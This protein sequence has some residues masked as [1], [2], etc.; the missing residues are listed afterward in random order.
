MAA[1]PDPPPARGEA[2][3][4]PSPFAGPGV[5]AG[6][7]GSFYRLR[8]MPRSGGPRDWPALYTS[9][10]A[11]LEVADRVLAALVGKPWRRPRELIVFDVWTGEIVGR[12]RPDQDR[13]PDVCPTCGQNRDPFAGPVDPAPVTPIPPDTG[14]ATP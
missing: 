3:P 6:G 5:A 9:T 10:D 7:P 14:P 8:E 11:A 4:G 1:P 2:I 12:A 13:D